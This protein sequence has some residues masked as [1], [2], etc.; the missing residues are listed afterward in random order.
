MSIQL[1]KNLY[2]QRFEATQIY[3]KRLPVQ[4][5]TAKIRFIKIGIECAFL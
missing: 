4:N 5:K 1:M 3:D 2:F